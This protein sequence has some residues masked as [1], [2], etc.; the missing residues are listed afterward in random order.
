MQNVYSSINAL[1]EQ[2]KTEGADYLIIT[3]LSAAYF[4]LGIL[5]SLSEKISDRIGEYVD[6]LP[7]SFIP[8]ITIH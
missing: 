6:S 3:D 1:E 8:D 5:T 2:R 4:H 7:D